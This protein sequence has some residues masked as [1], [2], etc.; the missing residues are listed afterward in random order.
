MNMNDPQPD[1]KL[2]R[3]WPAIQEHHRRKRDEAGRD[4]KIVDLTLSYSDIANGLASIGISPGRLA[5]YLL[6]LMNLKI[7]DDEESQPPP[8]QG[9][10]FYRE[11]VKRL[12]NVLAGISLATRDNTTP[13]FLILASIEKQCAAALAIGKPSKPA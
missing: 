3:L 12:R 6:D 7:A 9:D 4:Q 5:E 1:P 11:E 2:R 13:A 8:D 10:D